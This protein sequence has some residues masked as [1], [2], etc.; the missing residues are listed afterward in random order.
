MRKSYKSYS[1]PVVRVMLVIHVQR[2]KTTQSNYQHS[3]AIFELSLQN[4]LWHQTP[5][6]LAPE[7]RLPLPG[8]KCTWKALAALSPLPRL[9]PWQTTCNPLTASQN[10]RPLSAINKVR[11]T[12]QRCN[13][14]LLLAVV[15][16]LSLHSSPGLC[17]RSASQRAC[18]PCQTAS[19]IF[20]NRFPT[21]VESTS[22][23]ETESS[24]SSPHRLVGRELALVALLVC[25]QWPWMFF[26]PPLHRP[27]PADPL[28]RRN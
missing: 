22:R 11:L 18:P 15:P 17:H 26:A 25:H 7:T 1:R 6:P 24:A 21:T 27:S 4:N 8:S 9:Q 10:R 23:C 3:D 2:C 14:P 12:L 19:L 13:V 28:M 16:I 20:Q 5:V